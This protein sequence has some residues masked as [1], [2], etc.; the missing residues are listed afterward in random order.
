MP[1]P[2]YVVLQGRNARSLGKGIIVNSY[3]KLNLFHLWY[4]VI[5]IVYKQFLKHESLLEAE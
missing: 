4:L 2:Q 3:D 1:C 5:C